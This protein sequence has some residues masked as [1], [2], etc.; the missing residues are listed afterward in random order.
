[1]T[2]KVASL[3]QAEAFLQTKGMLGR[4][5][6]NQITVASETTFGLEIQLLE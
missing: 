6:A 1:M 2:W 3:E 4:V 5:T